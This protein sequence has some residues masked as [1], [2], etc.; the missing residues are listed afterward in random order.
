MKKLSN[1]I[2]THSK[3]INDFVLK[4]AIDINGERIE[5]IQF[6]GP[7][8]NIFQTE[9]KYLEE[10]IQN[11]EIIKFNEFYINS[12]LKL[13][14]PNLMLIQFIKDYLGVISLES[15]NFILCNCFGVSSQHI[16]NQFNSAVDFLSIA[17]LM[18]NT[19]A[20]MGCGNCTS[21]V[22]KLYIKKAI[23]KYKNNYFKENFMEDG[24]WL[25]YKNMSLANLILKIDEEIQK[26]L[27]SKSYDKTAITINGSSG[28]HLNFSTNLNLEYSLEE[29]LSEL[30]LEKLGLFVFFHQ[31]L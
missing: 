9:I 21:Q 2:F 31:D 5:E 27:L 28:F 26:W 16:Q 22:R 17:E 12:K 20:A 30:I 10:N 14:K 6:E 25:S 3:E 24:N 7:L 15:N 18:T 1:Q 4:V 29:T 8:T 23:E 11:F 13:S 19:K